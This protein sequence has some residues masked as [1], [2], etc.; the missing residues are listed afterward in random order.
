[1]RHPIAVKRQPEDHLSA[2]PASSIVENSPFIARIQ[3]ERLLGAAITAMR[4]T[5]R[6]IR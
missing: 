2:S 5:K 3:A 1:M 4:I 6:A